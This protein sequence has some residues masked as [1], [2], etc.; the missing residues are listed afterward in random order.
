MEPPKSFPHLILDSSF[1]SALFSPPHPP[2]PPP[3]PHYSRLPFTPRA[4]LF[5]HLPPP[6]SIFSLHSDPPLLSS[7]LTFYLRPSPPSCLIFLLPHIPPRYL[8]PNTP[9][10]PLLFL[11]LLLVLL[12]RCS[13]L[14]HPTQLPICPLPLQ[15]RINPLSGCGPRRAEEPLFT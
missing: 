8:L 12:L 15:N 4:I 10:P 7:V 9:F 1:S 13:S 5:I 11:V 6:N 14:I 2:S 3:P